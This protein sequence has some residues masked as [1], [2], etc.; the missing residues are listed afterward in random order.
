LP[1]THL[2]PV[3]SQDAVDVTDLIVPLGNAV[4]FMFDIADGLIYWPAGGI[5]PGVSAQSLNTLFPGIAYLIKVNTETTIDFGSDLP[6]SNSVYEAPAL[7]NA[8]TWNNV[9]STG[10]QHIISISKSALQTFES[11]DFVGVFN[12]QGLCAGMAHF[13]GGQSALPLVV[14]GND[15][16]T[17]VI[18]GMI[19][20]E[21][22]N[23]RIFRN[24]QTIDATAVY[25]NQ[26]ENNNGLFAENGLSIIS[27]LKL[28]STGMDELTNRL[29][30]YPNPSN[31]MITI[32]VDGQYELVVTNVQG[33]Q[34]FSAS[35]E[36]NASLDLSD[37]PAGIYFV[38]LTNNTQT[39]I[40]R[41][42]IR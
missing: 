30:I 6:K 21:P 42:L 41:I 10:S 37:Q 4:E 23:I 29:S 15:N 11:G 1:G 35:I 31:G 2:I 3:L 22:M 38:R 17:G 13:D 34:V 5:T 40:E 18:D 27:D 7:V 16:T 12:Q 39:L 8:T 33:Q 28:G 9:V 20:D 26:T 32:Q 24:G 14:Y 19:K 36:S 25:S